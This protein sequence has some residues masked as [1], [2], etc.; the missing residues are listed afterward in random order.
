VFWTEVLNTS[1]GSEQR[2]APGGA[3]AGHV[4]EVFHQDRDARERAGVLPR[5][6]PLIERPRLAEREFGPER[7]DGVE[8][9][10][11]P[12]D[13]LQRPLDELPGRGAARPHRAGELAKN[14]VL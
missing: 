10:V 14:P 2:G 8:L 1:P 5:G 13:A 12:R 3:Q 9:A 7:D 6:D 4:F 11:E